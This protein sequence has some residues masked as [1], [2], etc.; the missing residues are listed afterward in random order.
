MIRSSNRILTTHA[1]A[2]ACSAE[3]TA[4]IRSRAAQQSADDANIARLLR[5]EVTQT[6]RLQVEHGIDSVSDGKFSKTNVMHY[7][8]K[9][10]GGIE[11]RE[12]DRGNAPIP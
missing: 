10:I 4:M 6:L 1:G 3:L 7:A 12:Y 9:R 2:L 11:L 5:K 8:A